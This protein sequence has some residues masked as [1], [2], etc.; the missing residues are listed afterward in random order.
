MERSP[1]RP[2]A[3]WGLVLAGLLV[4]LPLLYRDRV[5]TLPPLIYELMGEG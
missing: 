5:T 2:F 3:A 1:T 4:Q